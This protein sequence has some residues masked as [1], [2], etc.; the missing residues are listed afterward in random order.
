MKSEIK[1][2]SKNNLTREELLK[3]HRRRRRVIISNIILIIVFLFIAGYIIYNL[4]LV[5]YMNQDWCSLCELKTG[6]KCFIQN[7]NPQSNLSLP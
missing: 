7:F 3:V 2:V 4:E 1:M 6:A 5:K